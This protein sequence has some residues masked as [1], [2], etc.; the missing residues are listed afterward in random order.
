MFD[1]SPLDPLTQRPAQSRGLG[2]PDAPCL[3]A[4]F[5]APLSAGAPGSYDHQRNRVRLHATLARADAEGDPWLHWE[6]LLD[7]G[8]LA[9]R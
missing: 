2:A 5:I 3:P 9:R 4:G 6:A 8:L 1:P 7:A